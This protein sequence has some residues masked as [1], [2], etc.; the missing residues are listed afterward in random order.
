MFFP[1]T[2]SQ[3]SKWHIDID[4][5]LFM[6]GIYTLANVVIVDLTHANLFF[7]EISIHGF[8]TLKIAQME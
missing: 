5:F 1:F 7:Q 2:T 8:A 6:D 3:I 4:I